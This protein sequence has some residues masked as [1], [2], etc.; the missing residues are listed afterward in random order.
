VALNGESAT[1][2]AGTVTGGNCGSY[3][4]QWQQLV[5]GVWTDIEAATNATY[6][7]P[8]LTA[9][10]QYRRITHCGAESVTSEIIT[11]TIVSLT[12]PTAVSA[13]KD[14]VCP[15]T[16]VQL[17]VS[18]GTGSRFV[19]YSGSCGVNEAGTGTTLNV[20]PTSTTTYW[21]RWENGTYT[22]ECLPV[23]V[24]VLTAP[25]MSITPPTAWKVGQSGTFTATVDAD[26]YRWFVDNVEQAGTAKSITI[27]NAM[28]KEYT[29]RC[30]ALN[31]LGCFSVSATISLVTKY[32]HDCDGCRRALDD[33]GV[34]KKNYPAY[35]FYGGK[36]C[37]AWEYYAKMDSN[38]YVMREMTDGEIRA[39]SM[40]SSYRATNIDGCDG[41]YTN[42]LSRR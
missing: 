29:I 19:W 3:T 8:T 26:S 27:E 13:N 1:L 15:G 4:Y 32:S 42:S 37:M 12:A 9:D 36:V 39:Q 2:N 14:D 5:V 34:S 28:K 20:S 11:V 35:S 40:M 10:T 38:I 7:T 31:V 23:T 22:T 41:V 25:T 6:T 16:T 17:S 33:I 21:G 18:G 30:D 24:N